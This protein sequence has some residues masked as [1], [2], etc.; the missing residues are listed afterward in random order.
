MWPV[1]TVEFIQK[2][3]R[4]IPNF[5][6]LPENHSLKLAEFALL[7]TSLFKKNY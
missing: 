5:A 4:L 2:S 3:R 1:S 7:E 6:L